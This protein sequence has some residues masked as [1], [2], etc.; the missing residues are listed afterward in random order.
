MSEAQDLLD[1]SGIGHILHEDKEIHPEE[2][3]G[4]EGEGHGKKH[5]PG[6]HKAS[7]FGSAMNIGNTIMGAGILALPQVIRQ[8]GIIGGSLIITVSAWFTYYSCA[9]L[10]KSKKSF[11][12]Q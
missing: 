1:Q 6:E 10:L 9:M 7:V 8:F 2:L 5:S 11:K 3:S 12:A 4:E